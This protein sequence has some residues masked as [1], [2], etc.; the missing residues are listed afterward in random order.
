MKPSPVV[1]TPKNKTG[2]NYNDNNS[3]E[4]ET[5]TTPRQ[6]S[7][8][9]M[10]PPHKYSPNCIKVTATLYEMSAGCNTGAVPQQSPCGSESETEIPPTPRQ[11]GHT[12]RPPHK[13]SPDCVKGTVTSHKMSA[14]HN[15]GVAPQKSP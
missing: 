10:R 2:K 8:C 6:Q 14:G 9:T 3:S 1:L 11:S 13:Y 15:I 5:E 7:G 12:M 4:S